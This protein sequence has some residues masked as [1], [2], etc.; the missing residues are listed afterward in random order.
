M[1]NGFVKIFRSM[2]DWEWYGDMLTKTVFLHLL[3]TVNI[4]KSRWQGIDI[5]KGARACSYGSLAKELNISIQQ[6]RTAISHLQL[7]QEITVKRYPKF[8]VI[9]IKKWS[10]YQDYQQSIN[11]ASNSQSTRTSTGNP[12]QNKNIR[13]KESSLDTLKGVSKEG[14]EKPKSQYREVGADEW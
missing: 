13:I 8:S 4:E 9:S 5:P 10:S 3:L 7:T 14:E 6:A 1:K 12:Q 11:I 2:T